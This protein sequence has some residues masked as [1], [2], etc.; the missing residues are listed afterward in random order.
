MAV[1]LSMNLQLAD[2]ANKELG[3]KGEG[4]LFGEPFNTELHKHTASFSTL[5]K[6]ESSLRKVF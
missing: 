5:N 2:M 4:L 6:V 3:P 1:L